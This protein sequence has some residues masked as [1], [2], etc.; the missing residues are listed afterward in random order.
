MAHIGDLF[1]DSTATLW[2]NS[3]GTDG[4]LATLT[5]GAAKVVRNDV[6][7]WMHRG[8]E[9][10]NTDGVTVNVDLAGHVGLNCVKV[11]MAGRDDYYL[12]MCQY[13]VWLTAG[14]AGGQSYAPALV[15]MFSLGA[16]KPEPIR[17]TPGAGGPIG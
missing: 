2:F 6:W 8:E 14:T 1:Y 15:G 3:R 17:V 5:G 11:D 12:D 13:E 10:E 16:H 9:V 7:P 4:A